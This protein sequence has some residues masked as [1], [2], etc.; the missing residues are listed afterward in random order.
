[1]YV[2][3]SI[4]DRVIS[5]KWEIPGEFAPHLTIVGLNLIEIKSDHGLKRFPTDEKSRSIS[6]EVACARSILLFQWQ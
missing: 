6:P 1:M 4:G 2:G 3:K 5:I